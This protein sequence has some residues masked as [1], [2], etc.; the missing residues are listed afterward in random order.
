M[1]S[2]IL[3]CKRVKNVRLFEELIKKLSAYYSCTVNEQ[4]SNLQQKKLRIPA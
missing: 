4:R 3:K 1:P 2:E